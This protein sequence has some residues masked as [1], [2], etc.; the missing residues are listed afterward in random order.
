MPQPPGSMLPDLPPVIGHR[1]AAG[2]APENTL[3]GFRRAARLGLRWIECDVRCTAD[4]VPVLLHDAN[5]ERTTDGRGP[6]ARQSARAVAG[7]DAGS[8]FGAEF[9]GEPLPTLA[10]ALA[11]WRELGLAANLE[12]KSE[13]GGAA[14]LVDAVA[15]ALDAARFP[16]ALLISSFEP[17]S[18]EAARARLP[19]LPRGLLCEELSGDAIARA[20][21]LS[22]RS[23]HAAAAR[24]APEA[25]AKARA[26]GLE[27]LAY[28]VNEPADARRLWACGVR[29]VFSDWPERLTIPAGSAPPPAPAPPG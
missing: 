4:G 24:L 8:W 11:C 13:D 10:A 25:V 16:G 20:L 21:A 17:E 22:C 18:I 15:A 27:V 14:A 9:A 12:L 3:A 29:S 26:G 1:G 19:A 6:V 2:S 7:L 23:V 5:L 28:T